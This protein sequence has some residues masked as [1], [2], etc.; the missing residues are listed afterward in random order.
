[1][2]LNHS[3]G[4]FIKVLYFPVLQNSGKILSKPFAE[5]KVWNDERKLFMEDDEG[6]FKIFYS[7]ILDGNAVILSFETSIL[8]KN[9]FLSLSHLNKT[10]VP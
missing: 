4:V 2:G 8:K 10:K 7:L 9:T 1:M 6:H 3:I 5:F